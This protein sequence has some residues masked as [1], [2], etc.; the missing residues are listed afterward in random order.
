MVFSKQTDV[1]RIAFLVSDHLRTQQNV[2]LY[3]LKSSVLFYFAFYPN[4]PL[5]RDSVLFCKELSSRRIT[6]SNFY[7]WE[8]LVLHEVNLKANYLK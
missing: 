6:S 7:V 2:P 4:S 3:T 1:N 5:T 8:C